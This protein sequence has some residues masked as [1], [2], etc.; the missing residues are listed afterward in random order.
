MVPFAGTNTRN[1]YRCLPVFLGGPGGLYGM[2]SSVLVRVLSSQLLEEAAT[3][4]R[5][6]WHISDHSGL[7]RDGAS[8]SVKVIV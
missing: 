3:P 8:G 7:S 5:I 6:Q 1:A 4:V 2:I